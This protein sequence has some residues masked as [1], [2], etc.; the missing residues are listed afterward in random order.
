[1]KR[2]G[3]GD[4]AIFTELF[5]EDAVW[6]VP[7]SGTLSGPKQGRDAILAFFGE[8]FARSG[9]TMKVTVDDVIGGGEHTVALH[10]AHAERDNKV[11]DQHGV[12][13][14]RLRGG[15]VIEVSEFQEDTASSAEFWS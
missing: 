13:V 8:L 3:A 11:I 9:G 14:F 10:H 1:M 4:M 7:G 2:F 6:H 15:Q 5:A 12:N